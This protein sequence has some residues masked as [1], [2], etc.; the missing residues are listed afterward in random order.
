MSRKR[1]L[2]ILSVLI[3]CS[4]LSFAQSGMS[5]VGVGY[6]NPQTMYITAGQ[7]TTFLIS[8]VS[9][10]LPSGNT[11][12][13]AT[14]FPLPLSLGGFSATISQYGT[15][16]DGKLVKTEALPLLEVNQISN[17]HNAPAPP[18]RECILTELTVQI[19]TDLLYDYDH[20]GIF[21]YATA[22]T[23]SD[24]TGTSQSFN[25]LFVPQ[26]VHIMTTC[27]VTLPAPVVQTLFT[28]GCDDEV[29]HLNGALVNGS[30]PAQPG[31][32]LVMYA[33]G[34]GIHAIPGAGTLGYSLS[35]AYT[36]GVT[37]SLQP[38]PV[39]VPNPSFVGPVPGQVGLYQ[40]NFTV[41]APNGP[42]SGCDVSGA[43]LR[44]ILSTD[45]SSSP[46]FGTARICVSIAAH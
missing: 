33:L 3:L 7:I 36:G 44:I 39:P 38:T 22:I 42:I 8:G 27:D 40:V 29:T 9:T 35:F 45:Y 2:G 4:S 46:S 43:N 14:Q 19:P 21:T 30:S 13:R 15:D 23:I 6:K 31:E 16:T 17:C 11:M 41:P 32:V 25:V 24:A 5:L 37:L 34:L 26:N 10:I 28:A 20:T 12:Q 18:R 1:T